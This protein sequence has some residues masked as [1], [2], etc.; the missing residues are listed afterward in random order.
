MNI[1]FQTYW[2]IDEGLTQSTVYPNI[3]Q[4]AELPNVNKIIL[5][6]IERDGHKVNYTG[7]INSKIFHNPRYSKNLPISVL[8][9]IFDFIYFSISLIK[10]C[11]KEKIDY[12]IGRGALA[13][14]LSII[15]GKITKT[16]VVVESFEPHAQYMLESG[17][18]SK[19]GLKYKFGSYWENKIVQN[20]KFVITVS[21]NFKTLLVKAGTPESKVE[22]VPCC[23]D[24]NHFKFDKVNRN[25]LREKLDIH[26]ITKLGI[27][28]GKF[29]ALYHDLEAYKIFK[30]VLEIFNEDFFLIILTP[31]NKE[32]VRQNLL[33][34]NFPETKFFINKVPH[35]EVPYYLS[36]ADFSFALQTPKHSN[37]YL[38]PIKNGEYW[39]NGLPILSTEGVGD[40]DEIIKNE[41][42]GF[43]YDHR[44]EESLVQA[45]ESIKKL[46]YS[47]SRELLFEKIFETAVKHRNFEISKNVYKKIF[48]NI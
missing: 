20:A 29:G 7:P 35:N 25:K 4:L 31:D 11:K 23:V 1:L 14:A 45:I 37:L 8:N 47:Q 33:D 16:P 10:I 36:A 39:A 44:K 13:G 34:V 21:N 38:S 26:E 32:N 22:V 12:I 30:K 43:C 40:D 15:V 3:S 19:K 6:T 41:G 5:S 17:V 42:V 18:W 27:Y 2:G 48:G 28:V 9:K 24:L 46:I